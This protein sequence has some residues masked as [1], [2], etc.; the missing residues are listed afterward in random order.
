MSQKTTYKHM[1]IKGGN[2]PKLVISR[3]SWNFMS[4]ELQA[5]ITYESVISIRSEVIEIS[6]KVDVLNN[7]PGPPCAAMEKRISKLEK[8]KVGKMIATAIG[9]IAGG[10]WGSHIPK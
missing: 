4:P 3:E 9:S 6:K 8:W 7:N 2:D 10:I 1:D 5:R